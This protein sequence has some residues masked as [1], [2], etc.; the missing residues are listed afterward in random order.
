MPA[1]ERARGNEQIPSRGLGKQSGQR[2]DQSAVCPGQAR[3]GDLPTQDAQLVAQTRIST[4]LDAS[5]RARSPIPALS[6][7]KIRYTSRNVTDA[8]HAKPK[9][10]HITPGQHRGQYPAP[11]GNSGDG[12]SKR[13]LYDRVR[14]VRDHHREVNRVALAAA[15][16]LAGLAPG[17]AEHFPH[18]EVTNFGYDQLD[19]CHRLGSQS[20]NQRAENPGT[21]ASFG[22]VVLR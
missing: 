21:S 16:T 18:V 13:V 4:V 9:R 3:A 17:L 11:T 15:S 8:D 5:D 2:T 12:T 22:T 7:Q 1:Q 10:T 14:F 20:P 6:W 19:E